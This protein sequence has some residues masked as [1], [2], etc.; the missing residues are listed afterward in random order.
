MSDVTTRRKKR[1]VARLAALAIV[2]AFAS[3]AML[4]WVAFLPGSCS[5]AATTRVS[6]E[7]S[8]AFLR[9]AGRIV[10]ETLITK[11]R[12]TRSG[13]FTFAC[14]THVWPSAAWSALAP[15]QLLAFSS[16]FK[17]KQKNAGRASLSLRRAHRVAGRALVATSATMTFGYVFAIHK[18][19]LHFH[20]HD[21]PSLES[22]EAFSAAP[23]LAALWRVVGGADA[24]EAFE[25]ACACWFFATA[26]RAAFVAAR[27]N[28]ARGRTARRGARETSPSPEGWLRVH[29]AWAIRHLAAGY[30]VVAQRAL[31]ALA[32]ATCRAW[33]SPRRAAVAER[34]CASPAAQKGIFADALV[35]G[36]ALCVAAG[37]V[38]IRDADALDE[39]EGKDE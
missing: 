10:P 16:A 12:D 25:H 5:F 1:I 32:H 21:F 26:A 29:R 35:L 13:R 37:E 27:G 20:K 39:P 9:R 8:S 34:A 3:S 36:V 38:A 6:S 17:F 15:F 14:V 4:A 33:F 2:A 28:R 30:S 22:N 19:G 11:Y 18:K 23:A 31:I 24:F 7:S